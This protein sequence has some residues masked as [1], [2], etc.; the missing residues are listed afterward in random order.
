VLEAEA[1]RTAAI[2]DLMVADAMLRR[3]IGRLP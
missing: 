1:S 3:A 2:V